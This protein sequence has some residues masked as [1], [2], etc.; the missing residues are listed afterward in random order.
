MAD[1]NDKNIERLN[2][3][4]LG[5]VGDLKDPLPPNKIAGELMLR[6]VRKN[7]RASGRPRRWKPSR[8]VES[9][10]KTLIGSSRSLMTSVNKKVTK[11]RISVGTNDIRAK[12]LN[13]GGKV[14]A[15]NA[16]YLTI[17]AEGM[18]P[19]ERRLGLRA[20]DFENTFFHES[21]NGK[22]F[23]MQNMG[24]GKKPRA[25]FLLVKQMTMP[26]RPFIL[27]QKQDV[28]AITKVY[29][30]HVLKSVGNDG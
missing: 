30:D 16:K 17:P 14:R 11:S 1:T 23:L 18:T 21:A 10:H 25:L 8:R 7:F 6:S 5:I 12:L 2:K 9:G 22:L 26:A 20:R 27:F 4:L 15:K 19:N 28:V 3:K 29:K 13:Y 24:Q